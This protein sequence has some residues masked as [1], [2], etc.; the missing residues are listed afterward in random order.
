[1]QLPQIQYL[2]PSNTDELAGLLAEHGD[3]A[4]I[5]AGGTDIIPNMLERFVKAQYLIDIGKIDELSGISYEPGKGLEIG[6]ATKMH[7][8]VHT[9]IIK[10]KYYALYQAAL[11]V[12]SPAIRAMA[13][14]GGN[15]CNASP[16][17]D[18]PPPLV[19]LGAKVNLVSKRG[20]REMLLEDFI[21]GNRKTAI[22]PDEFLRSFELPDPEP[23]SA[24]RFDLVTLRAEVEIDI[25]AL[26]LSIT[27]T[28]DTK[29]VKELRISM[30]AVAPIPMR[31]KDAEK[32]LEAQIPDDALIEK[33]AECCSKESKPIDDFR[34]SASYR[35]HVIKVLAQRTLKNALSA[36]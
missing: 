15:S 18:T 20:S 13:S 14:I 21:E 12:G 19:A 3:K 28:P 10:E 8:I 36:I 27:L 30:G 5:L 26:A 24:S 9:P 32:I 4:K 11:K 34:A 23:N 31:A 16:A 6:T 25:V 22:E 33:V 17:A 7:E 35:R 29:K 1:M 2:A